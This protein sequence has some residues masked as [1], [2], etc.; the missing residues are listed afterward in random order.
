MTAKPKS[1]AGFIEALQIFSEYFSDRLDET[2]FC[3]GQHDIILVRVDSEQI[4]EDSPQGKQL[5]ELGWHIEEEAD[6]TWGY[7][8]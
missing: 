3:E 2:Y 4:P 6:N 8:T 7:F 1:V 5:K